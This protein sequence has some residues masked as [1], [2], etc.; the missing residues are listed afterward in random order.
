MIMPVIKSY[1]GS[2]PPTGP[3]GKLLN[4]N[5]KIT[6]RGTDQVEFERPT[7]EDIPYQVN[8]ALVAVYTTRSGWHAAL[9]DIPPA[10]PTAGPK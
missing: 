2:I 9:V 1:C 3:F 4:R 7:L 6:E 8:K 10:P 5:A